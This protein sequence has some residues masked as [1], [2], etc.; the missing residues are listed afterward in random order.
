MADLVVHAESA[1]ASGTAEPFGD[2]AAER[3]RRAEHRRAIARDTIDRLTEKVTKQRAQL[4]D[5]EAA[6]AAAIAALGDT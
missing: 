5:A 4:A 1:G 6:L 2:E 3:V